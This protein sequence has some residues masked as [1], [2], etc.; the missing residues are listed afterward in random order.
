MQRASM[1]IDAMRIAL[2]CIAV[3][4]A[5]CAAPAAEPATRSGTV[6]PALEPEPAPPVA[7][8]APHVER[9]EGEVTIGLPTGLA[10]TSDPHGI[11]FP[12]GEVVVTVEEKGGLGMGGW[13]VSVQVG[14][15][16]VTNG[17]APFVAT[18]DV[19]QYDIFI[20]VQGDGVAL[21]RQYEATATWATPRS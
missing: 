7:E 9:W 8:A 5:G 12:G 13:W 1:R 3:L 15:Q 2:L 11:A 21:Q 18:L 19:G 10:A 17:A 20:T 6:P 16:P 4:L 14:E